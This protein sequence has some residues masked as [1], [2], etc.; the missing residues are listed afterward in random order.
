MSSG[1][2]KNEEIVL[3]LLNLPGRNKKAGPFFLDTVCPLSES[4]SV[5]ADSHPY[6][7]PSLTLFHVSCFVRPSVYFLFCAHSPHTQADTFFQESLFSR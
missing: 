4:L 3:K 1:D 7:L 2:V 6:L 5:F